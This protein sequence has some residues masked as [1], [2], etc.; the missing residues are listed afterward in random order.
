MT[1]HIAWIV[2]TANNRTI[3][4]QF[5]RLHSQ[6]GIYCV[7]VLQPY[8]FSPV[9]PNNS[10]TSAQDA[11]IVRAKRGTVG[12]VCDSQYEWIIIANDRTAVD[13]P[14]GGE[15]D[16]PFLRIRGYAP[17]ILT[18]VDDDPP[19]DITGTFKAETWETT[20]KLGVDENFPSAIVGRDSDGSAIAIDWR[21]D[22]AY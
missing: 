20:L 21:F 17:F 13:Y 18:L 9:V 8:T 6:Y 14:F 1:A 12:L 2:N 3:D 5:C 4:F 10:F 19:G 16:R 7:S 22:K 15:Q 11:S